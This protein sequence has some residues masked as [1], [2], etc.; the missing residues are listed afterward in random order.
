MFG[1]TGQVAAEVARRAGGIEVEALDRAAADLSN[2]A[3]CAALVKATDADII[4]NAAAYTA[5]DRAEDEEA[6][7]A[8]V[9]GETPTALANAAA[10]RNIPFLHISTDYVFDGSGDAPW[11]EDVGAAPLGAYGWT[12]LAGEAGVTSAGGPH[13][14]LRTSWVFSAHGANFVK[15]MLR[16]GAEK[17][18]LAIVDDQV[19]GPTAAGDVAEALLMMARAF[20]AGMGV[21]GIYHFAGA[22]AVSW[23]QFADAIFDEAGLSVDV[24]PIPTSDYPTSAKRPQNSRLDCAKIKADYG[25]AQPDWRI[26]L[27]QVIGELK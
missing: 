18:A 12:K 4:L 27:K 1:R 16:L 9:N 20:H 26:S 2:P 10:A 6:T 7:A 3:A 13:V 22:P 23:R 24:T 19:G 15:T 11:R 5:V 21:S 14:I 25:I 8:I 17:D